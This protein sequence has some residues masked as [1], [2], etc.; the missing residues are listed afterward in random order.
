MHKVEVYWF[1]EQPYTHVTDADL[2]P[3]N[4]GRLGFLNTYFDPAKAN[5]LY[6]QYHKQSALA[7]EVGFD[8]M[9]SNEHNFLGTYLYGTV[10]VKPG[11]F[12]AHELAVDLGTDVINTSTVSFL[13]LAVAEICRHLP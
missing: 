2:E 6:N 5:V 8:G 13:P 3:Y 11:Q 7:D 12:V 10:V 4:S 9:M 1:S